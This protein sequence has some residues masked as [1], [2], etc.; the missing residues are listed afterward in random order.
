MPITDAVYHPSKRQGKPAAYVP[1][2]GAT[3]LWRVIPQDTL[4]ELARR[5]KGARRYA[6]RRR[7]EG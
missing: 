5:N 4:N 2:S 3:P 7:M 6:A 1:H